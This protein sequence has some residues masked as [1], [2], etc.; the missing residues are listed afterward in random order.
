L[1]GE[2]LHFAYSDSNGGWSF[3]RYWE[4][5]PLEGGGSEDANFDVSAMEFV[6]AQALPHFGV[7]Y[8][9]VA[10]AAGPDAPALAGSLAIVGEIRP[11]LPIGTEIRTFQRGLLT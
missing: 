7:Y 2:V 8:E 1:A 6:D 11:R 9:E 3:A 10:A 4:G 5:Q